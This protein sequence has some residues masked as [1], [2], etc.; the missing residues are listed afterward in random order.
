MLS[1][2]MNRCV[3][4]AHVIAGGSETD[5]IDTR[6]LV[7]AALDDPEVGEALKFLGND[8]A[9]LKRLLSACWPDGPAPGSRS[10]KSFHISEEAMGLLRKAALLAQGS[11]TEEITPIGFLRAFLHDGTEASPLL[12]MNHSGLTTEGI[13]RWVAGRNRLKAIQAREIPQSL[14]GFC[15]DL[16]M[17]ALKGRI[18]A[19]HG[20]EEEIASVTRILRRRKKN[21]PILVGEPGVG[22]T[23]VVEGLALMIAD[24]SVG[25]GLKDA[26]ILSLN[27][28][29]FISGTKNRGDLEE[30]LNEIIRQLEQDPTLIL[31]IDEIHVL[32]GGSSALA[33]AANLLK[34]SLASGRVRCIGATTHGEYARYFDSDPA[35][36]RRFLSVD[37]TE[38]TREKAFVIVSKASTGYAAHHRVTYTEEAIRASVDLSIR[39]L[40]TR[41]LPD[42]AIDMIDEAGVI[43]VS[44]GKTEVTMDHV[45]R[46]VSRACG[47]N[48]TGGMIDASELATFLR[49]MVR[50]QDQHCKAVAD[51]MARADS[52]LAAARGTRASIMLTGPSGSGKNHLANAVGKALGLVVHRLDMGEFRAE[53]NVTRLIG[54]PPGYVGYG[55]GGLLTEFA[56]R[57]PACVILLDNLDIAHPDVHS[58]I[59]QVVETGTLRDTSG[60]EVSFGGVVLMMTAAIKAEDE[61][62]F[63]FSPAASASTDSIERR[64]DPSFIQGLDL[65][66]HLSRLGRQSLKRI[67]LDMIEGLSKRARERGLAVDVDEE[68]IDVVVEEAHA[69]AAGAKPLARIFRRV[70]ENPFLDRGIL[71]ASAAPTNV[72]GLTAAVSA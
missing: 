56:R 32:V 4:A 50:G 30:R 44:E 13:D 16:V 64:F 5:R 62:S 41:R 12:I 37:V 22:K 70:I 34:P 48:V 14:R 28:A 17:E 54:P 33:D 21:N 68:I 58:I 8:S 1:Q 49:G 25:E 11:P 20:R 55:G 63:G 53:N 61:K 45:A 35:M 10:S 36:A 9:N 65:V 52:P 57:T 42:K 40:L 27:L 18:D 43:A 31:F 39:H 24:G 47:R 3:E 2:G 15:T 46:A 6:H 29:S 67:V 59:G 23:A 66:V 19:V 51:V 38:P 60:R 72:I 69:E 7:M 71:S 26:R